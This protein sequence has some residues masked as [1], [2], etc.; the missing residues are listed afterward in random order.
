MCVGNLGRENNQ[1]RKNYTANDNRMEK[2]AG[3]SETNIGDFGRYIR[4]L[5]NCI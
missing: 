2:T 5:C 3:G 1:F 4:L